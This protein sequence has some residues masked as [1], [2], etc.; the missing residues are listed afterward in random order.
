MQR[1]V[2]SVYGPSP[3]PLLPHLPEG[4]TLLTRTVTSINLYGTILLADDRV[5]VRRYPGRRAAR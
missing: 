5:I 4:S 2:N 1:R 3:G